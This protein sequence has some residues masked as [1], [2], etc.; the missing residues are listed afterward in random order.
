MGGIPVKELRETV[1][2]ERSHKKTWVFVF[3]G[4]VLSKPPP[5]SGKPQLEL[6]CI[7]GLCC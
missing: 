1:G 3:S 6:L 2:L 4:L 5:L 7:F